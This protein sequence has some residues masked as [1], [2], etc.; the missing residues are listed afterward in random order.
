MFGSLEKLKTSSSD[1]DEF[2]D[3][4]GLSFIE[5]YFPFS[6]IFMSADLSVS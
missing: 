2:F 4:H 1:E 3:A 6:C 5:L